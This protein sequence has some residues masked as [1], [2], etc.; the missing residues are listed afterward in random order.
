MSRI[1]DLT[2]PVK[3]GM[4]GIPKIDFYQKYPTR[5]QAVTVVD[6]MQRAKVA[7]EGVDL[8]ADAPAIGSMNTVFTL[9]THIG[10]HI[11]APRHFYSD[12][13]SISD[14][15]L[16]RI[17]MREAVVIDVSHKAAG[18]GVAAE[19][20]ERSK[21][22]PGAGQIAVIKT[23]WTDRAF[24]KPEFWDNTIYLDPSVGEWIER[25][26]VS[27]VAMDCFPEKPFWLMTLTPAERGANH[28]RWLKAGIP[29]I[30]MITGLDQIAPKFTMVALPLNLQ[31]MDGAPARV[32]GIEDR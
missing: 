19:D 14:V 17:V 29:M 11:D 6:E 30:Q 20:L 27:A 31:G 21:V 13:A 7:S 24:G 16:D 4:A 15:K 26:D 28:K 25:H 18:E 8:L 1:V 22:K 3:S 5:V 10:T 9:N 32:I 12:G 2:L 23:R